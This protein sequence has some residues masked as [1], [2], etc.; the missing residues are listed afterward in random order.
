MKK[1][2]WPKILTDTDVI[3][4]NKPLFSLRFLFILAF[5]SSII[6][7]RF[8][9]IYLY[10]I[11]ISKYLY[12]Y[13]I[14][15]ISKIY[16][17]GFFL[18]TWVIFII[19]SLFRLSDFIL[20]KILIPLYTFISKGIMEI[21]YTINLIIRKTDL[22]YKKI[23]DNNKNFTNKQKSTKIKEKLK[24]NKKTNGRR[25]TKTSLSRT[26]RKTS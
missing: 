4:T 26:Q 21:I 7:Y 12:D 24:N 9:Y 22:T 1:Q 8:V 17:E 15:Y 13:K 5:C 14:S 6:F 11:P 16:I 25:K 2:K 3:P 10:N 20:E 18:S 23:K 19:V